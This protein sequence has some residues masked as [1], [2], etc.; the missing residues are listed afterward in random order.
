MRYNR[1]SRNYGGTLKRAV[2]AFVSGTPYRS[3]PLYAAVVTL[4]VWNGLLT[5]HI[6]AQHY[7]DAQASA[8]VLSVSVP[9]LAFL[10]G[11]HPVLLGLN[12]IVREYRG[13]GE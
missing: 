9:L 6:F 3:L 8:D 13:G 1:L 5:A 10:V 11:I 4:I 2:R 12:G 7:P